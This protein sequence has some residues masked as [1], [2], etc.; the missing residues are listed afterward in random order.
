MALDIPPRP[1]PT[2]TPMTIGSARSPSRSPATAPAAA[3]C[4]LRAPILVSLD[5]G[6]LA[7]AP[8]HLLGL[9]LLQRRD[10]ELAG[11]GVEGHRGQLEGALQGPGLGF[12]VLH[13][14]HRH[15]RAARDE[16]PVREVDLV[17]ADRVAPAPVA[18]ARG[19]TDRDDRADKHAEQEHD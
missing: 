4:T 19:D 9:P 13:A 10:L 2:T 15:Q 16:R 3:A 12:D 11:R 6:E 14:P 7:D 5:R 8:A 17:L 18:Q 1:P